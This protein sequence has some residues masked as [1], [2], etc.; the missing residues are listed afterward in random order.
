MNLFNWLTKLNSITH[1]KCIVAASKRNF[2]PELFIYPSYLLL[3][4]TVRKRFSIIQSVCEYLMYPRAYEYQKLFAYL[5]WCAS[6]HFNVHSIHLCESCRERKSEGLQ[7]SRWILY[8]K[9][10][11]FNCKLENYFLLKMK[12]FLALICQQ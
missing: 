7:Y 3:L 10:I 9:I 4:T 6:G 2:L 8:F 1:I 5:M 11:S 12:T